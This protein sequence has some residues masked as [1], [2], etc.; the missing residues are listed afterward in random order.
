[1]LCITLH[2]NYIIKYYYI[3]RIIYSRPES[4][5]GG[6]VGAGDEGD[7]FAL[8]IYYNYIII[9]YYIIRIMFSRPE[10]QRGGE[11]GAGDEGGAVD[12]GLVLGIIAHEKLQQNLRLWRE[13]E[14]VRREGPR[15]NSPR[16]TA[17][18]SPP[19]ER[20]RES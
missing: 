9:Y 12:V 18:E 10:S 5:R 16:E 17:A 1:M 8:Y 15:H 19:V 7:C 4:Q 3:V 14:R 6:E 13:R 20:A 2:Y 11:V